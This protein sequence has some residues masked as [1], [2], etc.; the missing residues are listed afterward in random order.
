MADISPDQEWSGAREQIREYLAELKPV[1]DICKLLRPTPQAIVMKLIDE[2]FLEHACQMESATSI[3]EFQRL[4]GR[5]SF[6]LEAIADIAVAN[7]LK[8]VTPKRPGGR[9]AL[10]N[11]ALQARS[12]QRKIWG[13]DAPERLETRVINEKPEVDTDAQRQLFSDP[14]LRRLAL[15]R[16]RREHEI[17]SQRNDTGRLRAKGVWGQLELPGPRVSPVRAADGCDGGDTE[18]PDHQCSAPAREV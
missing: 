6:K 1:P 15:E 10:L 9:V 8:S 4:K 13:A 2:I 14:E 3:E 11:I 16:A 17:L 12:H 7:Y 18:A 5:H